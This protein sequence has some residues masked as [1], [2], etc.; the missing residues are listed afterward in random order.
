MN[1]NE[2]QTKTLAQIACEAYGHENWDIMHKSVRSHWDNIASA[3]EQAILQRLGGEWKRVSDKLPQPDSDQDH[4]VIWT[5][6]TDPSQPYSVQKAFSPY[7][8]RHSLHP[9]EIART[10]ILL[11]RSHRHPSQVQTLPLLHD[12]I[13][14]HS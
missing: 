9:S 13:Q 1:M 11:T 12:A 4:L 5:N 3:V 10:P 7:Q 6:D 14:G 8:I 2:Q